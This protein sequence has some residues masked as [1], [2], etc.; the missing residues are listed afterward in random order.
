M[1]FVGRVVASVVKASQVVGDKSTFVGEFGSL[2]ERML[3]ESGWLPTPI[4]TY[5]DIVSGDEDEI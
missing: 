5:V 2:V 3:D 4:K 1:E